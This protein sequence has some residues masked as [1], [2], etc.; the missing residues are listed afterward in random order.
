MRHFLL[1]TCSI[2]LCLGCSNGTEGRKPVYPV[3]GKVTLAGGAPIPGASVSFAP[4]DGQPV[5]VGKTD[6]NGVFKLTT[7]DWQ[8]GAAAGKFNVL[9]SKNVS[10]S[11]SATP[12]DTHNAMKAG[13][14]A[15]GHS[16]K[17]KGEGSEGSLVNEKYG[18]SGSGL[19]AEVTASG[20]NEFNFPL[21]P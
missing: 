13:G 21:D 12:E 15:A 17:K 6:D 20:P 10:T 5:A 8:D 18:K 14:S 9:I 7:Y 3:T 16:A 11:A 1:F 4:L 2:T 19:S